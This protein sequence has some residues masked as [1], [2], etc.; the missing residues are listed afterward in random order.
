MIKGGRAERPWLGLTIAETGA[1]LSQRAEI[2]YVAPFTPAWEQKL[3]EG[4]VIES[5]NGEKI[6]AGQGSLIPAFQ[7]R[8]FPNIPGELVAVEL[9]NGDT[10]ETTTHIIIT[11][12]RPEVPLAEAAAKDTKERMAAPLF[13]MILGPTGQSG[14]TPSFMIKKVI[15][16]SIADEAGLSEQDPVSIKGFHIEKDAGIALMD[17]SV[18]KRRMGYIEMSMRLPANLDSPNTL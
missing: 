3:K 17:I 18:K 6:V 9:S 14:L 12:V 5:I 2:L 8:F 1:A 13:G 16:G 7:D 11:A 10:N 15:R 4:S